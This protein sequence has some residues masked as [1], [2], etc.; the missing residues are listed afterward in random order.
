MENH[1]E[2]VARSVAR[3][4]SDCKAA[5]APQNQGYKLIHKRLTVAGTHRLL[6]RHQD[7]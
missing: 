4:A 1:I 6:Q 5:P 3:N 2:N 7:P